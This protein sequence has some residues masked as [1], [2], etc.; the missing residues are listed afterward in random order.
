M[1][2]NNPVKMVDTDQAGFHVSGWKSLMDKHSLR[3][4]E[5][6]QDKQEVEDE[7]ET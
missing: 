6:G 1:K 2:L 5:G 7:V 4:G 3:E